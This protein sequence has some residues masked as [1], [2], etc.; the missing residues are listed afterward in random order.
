MA[1]GISQAMYTT[2]GGLIVGI[3]AM[4]LY[5][6]LRGRLNRLVSALESA[7]NGVLRELA[8]SRVKPG[9]ERK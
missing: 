1:N 4:A 8:A 2:F 7:C 3:L 6:I 5:D 9:I